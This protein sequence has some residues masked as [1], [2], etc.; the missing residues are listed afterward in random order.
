ML[1][2]G[3]H[4]SK[5]TADI[6]TKIYEESDKKL[7]DVDPTY[8]VMAPGCYYRTPGGCLNGGGVGIIYTPQKYLLDR[9]S[10]N[11]TFKRNEQACL[12]DRKRELNQLCKRDSIETMF[13]PDDGLRRVSL[14]LTLTLIG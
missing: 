10:A 3:R 13:K 1:L 14:T 8:G 7:P 11:A 4:L 5:H 6:L 9:Y 2:T 12:V